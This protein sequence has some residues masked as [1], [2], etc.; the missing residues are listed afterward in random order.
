M[1][2][3]AI[4]SERRQA[5]YEISEQQRKLSTL[6]SNLPGMVYRGKNAPERFMEFVSAGCM[7]LTGYGVEVL[8]GAANKG[9]AELIHPHDRDAV[10]RGL[11]KAVE[12][13]SPFHLTYRISTFDNKEKWVLEQ[14]QTVFAGKEKEPRL[15]GFVTDITERKRAEQALIESEERYRRFVETSV[16]GI[17]RM[18]FRE[19][20][21]VNLS[22]D[23]QV[24]RIYQHS[25]H[26]EANKVYLQQYAFSGSDDLKEIKLENIAPKLDQFNMEL[27]KKFVRNGYRLTNEIAYGVDQLGNAKIFLVNIVGVVEYRCLVLVWGMQIDVTE[28]KQIE[29]EQKILQVQVQQLQKHEALGVLASGIAHDFNNILTGNLGFTDLALAKTD[30]ESRVYYYLTQIRQSAERARD[31]VAQILTFSRPDP[32]KRTR[33]KMTEVLKEALAFL[34]ASLPDNIRINHLVIGDESS[35]L[36]DSS[37]MHQVVINLC[38]NASQAMLSGGVLS[39]TLEKICLTKDL[40]SPTGKLKPGDYMLF[41]VEDTGVGMSADMIARIFDPFFTTKTTGTGLGLSVV[42]GIVNS[43]SGAINVIS[44]PG[45][46]Y[47]LRSLFTLL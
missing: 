35:V 31:L 16:E 33:V 11:E 46:G 43:H 6:M 9:Y 15:E 18:E 44:K 12:E 20:I 29:E 27:Q 4:I 41:R 37:Q 32:G 25:Y 13:N 23:E 42:L 28:Q 47:V 22:I 34:T 3:N 8:V 19:P 21:P 40:Y 45:S 7:A 24:E 17:W 14:G 39:L 36:A 26:A 1:F 2:L 5:Q 10:A 38:T 30:P